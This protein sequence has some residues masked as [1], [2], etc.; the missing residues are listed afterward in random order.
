MCQYPNGNGI[1]THGNGI[2]HSISQ[3]ILRLCVFE[4]RDSKN[5]YMRVR[6]RVC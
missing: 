3:G 4:A 5:I 1:L 2:T 6:V